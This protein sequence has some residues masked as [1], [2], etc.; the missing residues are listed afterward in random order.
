M[1]WGGQQRGGSGAIVGVS[2]TS[3]NRPSHPKYKPPK[4]FE[5]K[6]S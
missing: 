2:A 6:Q 4:Q 1:A 3:K 5:M